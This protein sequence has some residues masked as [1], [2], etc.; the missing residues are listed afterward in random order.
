MKSSLILKRCRY[1]N[2]VERETN[3]ISNLHIAIDS[4]CTLANKLNKY[5][6]PF[7][8]EFNKSLVLGPQKLLLEKIPN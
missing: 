6:T 1:G 4:T 3:F 7:M 2:S 5:S 8:G